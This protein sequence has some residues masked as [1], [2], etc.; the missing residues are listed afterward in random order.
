MT[1]VARRLAGRTPCGR[2]D[3]REGRRHRRRRL[4]RVAPR[5]SG[6]CADGHD[7]VGIDCFTDYYPR[8]AKERNLAAAAR[9]LRASGWSRRACR[10]STSRRCS[11][12]STRST[13]SPPRPA[14]APP[15][16]ASSRTTPSTTCSRPSA[17]S[18]RR[19]RRG[20]PRLVYASSS[21]VY[22]D[23]RDAAA[24]RG[25]PAASRVSP[26]GVT[27][28]AAEHLASLY[29]RNHGL[30]TR[31]SL[32]F[33]TV[34]GPRQ[35]PDMAFHRFLKAARDGRRGHASSATACRRATSPTSTTSWPP[36]R[37][38]ALSGRPGSVY[39]VGGGERVA[40]ND[41]LRLDRGGHRQ[42][43]RGSSARRPRRAT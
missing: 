39:N 36:P 14:C 42:A 18:R 35:R 32:R 41:V 15:G 16:D 31:A 28:L 8:E 34:Y 17:C 12:A 38:A 43:A 22:G 6:C 20:R 29:H 25:R 3:A 4:H 5:R 9:A 19:S 2:C 7:V 37:S 23:S 30:P 27:K 13:T 24:A 11:T 26:Y 40:L 10:T 33:F 21:S 1:S